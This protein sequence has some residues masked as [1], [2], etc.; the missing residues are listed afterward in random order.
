MK[1]LD[2]VVPISV[3]LRATLVGTMFG[4]IG[5][6]PISATAYGS[7]HAVPQRLP[8]MP[9]KSLLPNMVDV[10]GGDS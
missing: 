7:K 5:L 10:D 8:P 2:E 3:R 9:D 4:L 6:R 1:P